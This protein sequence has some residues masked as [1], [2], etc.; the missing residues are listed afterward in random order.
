MLPFPFVFA[1]FLFS[2][3]PQPEH[4]TVTHLNVPDALC[5]EEEVDHGF[6]HARRGVVDQLSQSWQQ[7]AQKAVGEVVVQHKGQALDDRHADADV[8][9][10]PETG[11]GK[12]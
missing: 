9:P 6:A 5:D 3:H 12:R 11:D 8:A 1:L 2:A 7:L 4:V 10:V